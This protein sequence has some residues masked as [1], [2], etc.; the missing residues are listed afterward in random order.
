[1]RQITKAKFIVFDKLLTGSTAFV[2]SGQN[3]WNTNKTQ[4]KI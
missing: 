2:Q 1:M 4:K 3:L